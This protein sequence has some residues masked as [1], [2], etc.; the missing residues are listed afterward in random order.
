VV[1]GSHPPSGTYSVPVRAAIASVP[2]SDAAWSGPRDCFYHHNGHRGGA[3]RPEPNDPHVGF[4]PWIQPHLEIPKR[5][6]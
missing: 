4:W 3:V 5:C 2:V 1:P 6:A